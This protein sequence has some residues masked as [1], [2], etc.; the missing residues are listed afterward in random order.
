MSIQ[1]TRG[2]WY[3]EMYDPDSPTFRKWIVRAKPNCR[4]GNFP[5]SYVC[6][7]AHV[8]HNSVT[9]GID[10]EEANALLIAQSKNMARALLALVDTRRLSGHEFRLKWGETFRRL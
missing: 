6:D 3:A 4:E 7:I 2:Q 1:P 5:D 9:R 8:W 10:Q